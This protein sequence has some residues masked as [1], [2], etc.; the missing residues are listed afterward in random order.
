MLQRIPHHHTTIDLVGLVWN[1][2]S[3]I[4]IDG[5]NGSKSRYHFD[6]Y[7]RST[8]RDQK[9]RVVWSRHS[10]SHR[11]GSDKIEATAIELQY[12]DVWK[13]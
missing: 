11:A 8:G 5:V 3:A 7:F 10:S 4:E 9:P 6:L 13:S 2:A 12:V 1:E